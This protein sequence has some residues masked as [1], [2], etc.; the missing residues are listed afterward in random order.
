M[1]GVKKRLA[2]WKKTSKS[3]PSKTF[4]SVAVSDYLEQKD[5][6]PF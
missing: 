6:A 2:G 3:D 4:L 1:G 5:D